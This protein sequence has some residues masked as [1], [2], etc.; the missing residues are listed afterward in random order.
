VERRVKERLVGAAVLVAAAIILIPEMLSGPKRKNEIA[1]TNQSDGP[2]KTYTIDLN[3]SPGSTTKTTVEESA[4]PPESTPPAEAQPE[5]AELA[6]AGNESSAA[7]SPP[8]PAQVS[9]ES[10]AP[11]PQPR[12]ERPIA[13]SPPASPPPGEREQPQ[14]RARESS[15]SIARSTSVPTSRGWA[16]QL[17]S[18][19]NRA[20]AE[21]MV[22]DLS[23][24]GHTAFVMPVKS[25]T[26]TL[27]R[28]R[29]GPFSDRA[30]A[31]DALASIKK[32]VANAAVVAHP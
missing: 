28:V 14:V 17:G 7:T 22:E 25:G 9:P 13:S 18:F 3:R 2:F 4:P 30:A 10:P 15:P 24:S 11:Q 21:R 8:E 12:S 16:V 20:T 31:N 1:A 27:Y 19:S 5:R 26:N 6:Q 29:V 32:R 23:G